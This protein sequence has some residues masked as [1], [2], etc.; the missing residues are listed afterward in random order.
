MK[1]S[2]I[3]LSWALPVILG[4]TSV[5][6]IISA[7]LAFFARVE[8]SPEYSV[9]IYT[10]KSPFTGHEDYYYA[11]FSRNSEYARI[12]KASAEWAEYFD[13]ESGAANTLIFTRGI[14]RKL[15]VPQEMKS[16]ER[17]MDGYGLKGV[18]SDHYI[19]L[20]ADELYMTL[21]E[22]GAVMGVLSI[23]S[24]VIFSIKRRA[25][26]AKAVKET[27]AKEDECKEGKSSSYTVY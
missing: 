10:R 14:R 26:K 5:L 6:L 12:V 18:H 8:L 24:A 20:T 3:V 1:K 27:A 11:V 19:D 7:F 15:S 25:V 23:I 17:E 9:P 22:V 13:A 4:V 16:I 2:K 21:L